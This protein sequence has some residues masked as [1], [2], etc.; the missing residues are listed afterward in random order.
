[1]L[2]LNTFLAT[3]WGNYDYN[4]FKKEPRI[5]IHCMT[6]CLGT[7]PQPQRLLVV[8]FFS[9]VRIMGNGSA[10]HLFRFLFQSRPVCTQHYTLTR[11]ASVHSVAANL[12]DCG[13]AFPGELRVSPFPWSVPTL[14]AFTAWSVHSV[15]AGCR[16]Y[17]CLAVTSHLH[18]WQNVQCPSCVTAE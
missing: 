16:M 1:M 10:N 18:F 8:A 9:L 3:L 12:G 14:Q 11:E 6:Y 17:A 5:D 13:R 2:P 15:S 7:F 4:V